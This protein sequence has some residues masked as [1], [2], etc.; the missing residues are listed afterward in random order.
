MKSPLLTLLNIKAIRSKPKQKI[1]KII[2][3]MKVEKIFKTVNNSTFIII[4]D[5]YS[6]LSVKSF[7]AVI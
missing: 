5:T 1:L 7:H 6:T 2:I 3:Q 4:S